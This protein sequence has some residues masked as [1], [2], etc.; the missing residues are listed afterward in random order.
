LFL[1]LGESCSFWLACG[2]PNLFNLQTKKNTEKY[3]GRPQ[4]HLSIVP[5]TMNKKL[6]GLIDSFMN[7]WLKNIDFRIFLIV[8]QQT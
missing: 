4:N 7:K 2:F 3:F 1:G 5:Q 8:L 6:V